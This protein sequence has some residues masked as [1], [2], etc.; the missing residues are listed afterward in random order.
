M[1]I[2]LVVNAVL[3]VNIFQAQ[4]QSAVDRFGGAASVQQFHQW[5]TRDV[6]VYTHT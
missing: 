5:H 4:A 2:V 1:C 3:V 6:E